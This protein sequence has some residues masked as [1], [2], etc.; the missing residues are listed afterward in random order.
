MQKYVQPRKSD[1]LVCKLKRK[2]HSLAAAKEQIKRDAQWG[3]HFKAYACEWCGE[4]H[5]TS[6]GLKKR[7]RSGFKNVMDI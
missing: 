2:F 3:M 4:W 1:P 7:K 5:L 6:E